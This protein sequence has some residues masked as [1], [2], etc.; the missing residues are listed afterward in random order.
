MHSGQLG[1]DVSKL[2]EVLT[3]ILKRAQRWGAVLLIDEADVYIRER[4]TDMTQNAVVATFLR[5]LEYFNGLLFLT[6]NRQKD[7]DDAI[8]SR[9]IAV[10]RYGA[11][12]KENA[13]KIWKV[14][15]SQYNV[16]LSDDLIAQL[17]AKYPFA[18]GRDIKEL[19]KLV[20]RWL[21]KKKEPLSMEVFR[22]CAQFRGLDMT[23]EME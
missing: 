15:S 19:L 20:T 3:T 22:K 12:N 10:I 5:T 14:L 13:T 18:S 9:C 21:D 1:V 17:T 2:E 16:P 4:G 7:V 11:P 6:T 8:L 23:K